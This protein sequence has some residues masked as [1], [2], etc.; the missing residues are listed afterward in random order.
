MKPNATD[1]RGPRGGKSNL[2]L[3]INEEARYDVIAEGLL[4]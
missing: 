4:A 1:R 3:V 2:L